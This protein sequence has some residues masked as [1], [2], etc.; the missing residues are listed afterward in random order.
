LEDKH[1]SNLTCPSCGFLAFFGTE[2]GSYEICPVCAWEDDA[3]QLN[4]PASD[5]GANHVSL[6]E[7]QENILAS[8]P[9]DM[10]DVYGLKRDPLWRPLNELEKTIFKEE[11]ALNHWSNGGYT[12]PK[13]AYWNW[14][15]DLYQ[16]VGKIFAYWNPIGV[17]NEIAFDEYQ[18]Y[19]SEAIR[20]ISNEYQIKDFLIKLLRDRIGLNYDEEKKVPKKE[21]EIIGTK[22][23]RIV[24]RRYNH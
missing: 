6:I 12:E 18:P 13:Y 4:N 5:G 24:N 11:R 22:F 7:S 21:L 23:E 2:Y 20:A 19:V 10:N 9:P 15:K 8:F 3:V 1:R 14:G 16:D 17:P